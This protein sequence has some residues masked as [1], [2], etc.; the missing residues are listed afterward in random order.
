MT[1]SQIDNLASPANTQESFTAVN[2]GSPRILFIGGTTRPHSSTEKALRYSA[3]I[4]R[5]L[6]ADVD[7]YAGPDLVLPVYVPLGAELSPEAQSVIDAFR[8]C[9]GMIIGSP[10]YHGSYSGLI[11]NVL[12]YV[13]ELAD[14]RPPFLTGKAVGCVASALGWQAIGA[15]LIGLRSVAHALQGWNVPTGVGMNTAHKIFDDA[16]GIVDT[17]V[18]ESLRKM[19]EEVVL[20]ARMWKTRQVATSASGELA[21]AGGEPL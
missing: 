8:C 5:E 4:A 1:T 14:D 18:R 13:E 12:D 7:F 16:G 17:K 9:D 3:S 11:K 21:T 6:G 10:S 2:G 19:T 20:F 15:T